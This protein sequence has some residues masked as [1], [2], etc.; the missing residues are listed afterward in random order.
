MEPLGQVVVIAPGLHLDGPVPDGREESQRIVK[1]T[2]PLA[3][4]P[5]KNLVA[6]YEHVFASKTY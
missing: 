4:P 5:I 6:L 3:T 1:D 2:L